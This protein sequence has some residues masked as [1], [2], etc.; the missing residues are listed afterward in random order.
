LEN[1]ADNE[2]FLQVLWTRLLGMP[3]FSMLQRRAKIIGFVP[4]EEGISPSHL[5]LQKG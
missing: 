1:Q 4:Q 5:G 2:G 3:I